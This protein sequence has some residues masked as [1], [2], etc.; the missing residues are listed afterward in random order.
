MPHGR[1]AACARSGTHA[2]LGPQLLRLSAPYRCGRARPR[3]CR[4]GYAPVARTP[5]SAPSPPPPVGA[6]RLPHPCRAR[7]RA[8]T[9]SGIL[10]L[11]AAAATP[12]R[13][14]WLA[15]LRPAAQAGRCRL[16]RPSARRFGVPLPPQ[17][18][19]LAHLGFALPPTC[20][21][22]APLPAHAVARMPPLAP[23]ASSP[24]GAR[25]SPR[26]WT[27]WAHARAHAALG[28]FGSVAA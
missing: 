25:H 23:S 17:L 26:S 1:G 12:A 28:V 9:A 7:A 10:D 15:L 22:R 27:C 19:P 5:L 14:T 20:R 2:A 13:A 3:T 24:V 16:T 4:H 6:R 11:F 21:T 18:R 8:H